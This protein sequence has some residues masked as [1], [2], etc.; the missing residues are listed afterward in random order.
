MNGFAVG[1][2][3]LFTHQFP[4]ASR[5]GLFAARSGA[6]SAPRASAAASDSVCPDFRTTAVAP[7]A[8][9]RSNGGTAVMG[10]MEMTQYTSRP[11]SHR[12]PVSGRQ[13]PNHEQFGNCLA[14]KDPAQLLVFWTISGQR[15]V[16]NPGH[17][18]VVSHARCRI[19]ASRRL[20]KLKSSRSSAY[21]LSPTRRSGRTCICCVCQWACTVDSGKP[22]LLAT[23]I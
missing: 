11:G 15:S 14:S 23:S 10:S 12:G 4:A 19:S 16:P 5:K 3:R 2:F 9:G 20:G 17:R 7:V 18:R 8:G 6:G 21:A 22:G 13:E 1:R